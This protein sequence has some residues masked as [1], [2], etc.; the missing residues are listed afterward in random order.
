MNSEVFYATAATV[1]PLLLISV[2][3][4]RS[5]RPGEL[6][7]QSTSIMLIFGLPILGEIAAFAFL[8]FEP[9]PSAVAAFLSILTWA[10]LLSQLG[11]AAWWLASLIGSDGGAAV[12]K[13]KVCPMCRATF[14]GP[15]DVCNNCFKRK[16]GIQYSAPSMEA[17]NPGRPA[18]HQSGSLEELKRAD[19]NAPERHPGSEVAHL[20]KWLLDS[21][22]CPACHAGLRA[23]EGTSEVM[24]TSITCGLAYPIRDGIPVLLVQEARRPGEQA[25][26]ISKAPPT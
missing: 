25:S 8:F 22:A 12:R 5:L 14:A 18:G 2:I 20:D 16:T 15:A 13:L 26:D 7:R 10:G 9:M 11:L 4:T 24:C 23:D 19:G 3:A 21:L 6:R 1:I 17:A